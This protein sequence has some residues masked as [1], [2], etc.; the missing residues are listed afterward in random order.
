M[1]RRYLFF[2]ELAYAY[3]IIRPLQRAIVE[4]GDE[5]AWLLLPTCPDRLCDGE[6]RVRSLREAAD[7]APTA[8]FAPGNF[9]YYF[10]PGIKVKIFHGYPI[11]KRNYEVDNHF[12]LRGWFDMLC[13]QGDSS[14]IPF[15]R[16]SEE[17]PYF[18]VYKTGW[19]KMDDFFPL[20]EETA[21]VEVP[22]ILYATTFTQ[23]L[24]SAYLMPD[25]IDEIA[26]KRPWRW[27]PTLHPKLTDPQL[28]ARFHAL[29]EKHANVTFKPSV[30]VDDMRGTQA[31]LCDSSSIILEYMMLRK[32]VVTFRNSQPGE[33]LINVT[34]AAEVMP[35]IERALTRP[36]DLMRHIDEFTAH[37][38]TFR[39]GHN[40]ERILDAVD[41]FI[42]HYQGHLA[43]KP[44]NLSR[45]IIQRWQAMRLTF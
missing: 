6:Q 18:K 21:P 32:P 11:N 7:Y 24:T 45:K 10:L 13:T 16:L 29:A 12:R 43:P 26:S 19:A 1:A 2:A 5:A 17:R 3:S 35:A 4:R 38:E 34:S 15:Q 40:C 27:Q 22:T 14:Y 30:S 33:H 28:I 31:M 36:T 37:H 39:D 9:I 44:L 20:V 8:I 42:T 25:I 41:D 23:R